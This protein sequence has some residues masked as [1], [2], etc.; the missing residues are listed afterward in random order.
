M[1][2]EITRGRLVAFASMAFL[3]IVC[4]YVG[5]DCQ[6]YCLFVNTGCT[7]GGLACVDN[8]TFQY[9]NGDQSCWICGSKSPGNGYC[10]NANS[11]TWCCPTTSTIQYHNWKQ[12]S[13]MECSNLRAWVGPVTPFAGEN[14][15][16]IDETAYDCIHPASGATGCNN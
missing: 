3:G 13:A 1:A 5:A 10:W 11:N 12:N 16:D 6:Q 4:G 14:K 7:S 2:G 9:Q 15:T 8:T